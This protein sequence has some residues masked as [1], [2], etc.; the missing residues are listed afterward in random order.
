MGFWYE[1]FLARGGDDDDADD[2]DQY[3]DDGPDD[4]DDDD[5]GDGCDGDG[6]DDEDDDDDAPP[7]REISRKGAIVAVHLSLPFGKIIFT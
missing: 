1:M 2:D 5:D 4:D 3:Y 7:V 6:Y